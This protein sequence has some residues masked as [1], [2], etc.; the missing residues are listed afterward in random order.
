MDRAPPLPEAGDRWAVFLDVD[1]TLLAIA[2]TPGAVQ[3]ESELP[4]LLLRLRDACDGALA[5]VSG[6][7]L[8]D[9][10]RMFASLRG[11]AAGLHGRERRSA[12]GTTERVSGDAPRLDALRPLL[13][14]YV[15]S[16]PGLLLED[17]GGSLAVHYRLAPRYASSLGRLADSVAASEPELSVIR[18][19]KV[20]EFLPR[21][22]DKGVAI[23]EFLSEPPFAG[24]RPIYAGDDTTDEDGFVMVNRLGGLSIKVADRESRARPAT[25][26]QFR[27]PS[28]AA[29]R[30]WLDAVAAS[31]AERL[32]AIAC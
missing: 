10:D 9:I 29:L 20:V 7:R 32:P 28:V 12:Q 4:A 2:A 3:V 13:D 19:R 11:P 31:L 27:L 5:L 6:R 18:G 16:R 25:A 30:R 8:A 17:K 1:G 24:R 26:A 23:S 14:A 22:A 15:A 21:G